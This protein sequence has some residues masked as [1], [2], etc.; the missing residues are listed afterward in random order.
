MTRAA[1]WIVWAA[2]AT[3]TCLSFPQTAAPATL[4]SG[5]QE[6]VVFSGLTNPTDVRFA[7]D[8]RVFV[9]REERAHQGRS[10]SLRTDADGRRRPADRGRRLLGPRAPRPGARPG[11]PGARRTSTSLYTRDA[12]IG[13]TRRGDVG[14]TRARRRP[15]RRPT[16]ASSRPARAADAVGQLDDRSDRCCSTS[17]C[18][19]YPSHSI[20]DLVFGPDGALYVE[21]RRRR[22][23]HLRRLRPGWRLAGSPT[24]KNPCGDPPGGRR[25]HAEPAD[26]RGRRAAGQS[27]RR[28]AGEPGSSNGPSSGSIPT[29]G[30]GAARQPARPRARRERAAASSPTDCAT[31]SASRSAPG[32][33]SS[34]SATSAGATGRRSTASPTRPGRSRTS[35]GPATRAPPAAGLPERGLNICTALYAAGTVDAA[36]TSPRTTRPGRPRRGCPTGG[37][38]IT[39]SRSTRRQLPAVVQRRALLRRLHA[40][41]HLGDEARRERAARPDAGAA[42]AVAASN[43]VDLETGPNGDIFYVDLVG[44][45]IRRIR[46]RRRNAPPTVA[47]RVADLRPASA[48]GELRRRRRRPTRSRRHARRTRGI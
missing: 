43:P 30:R 41:L 23:L 39:G 12:P 20:G 1:R 24:P 37:S 33:T 3:I 28:P 13:G 31:R 26:R 38:S 42:F 46:L 29:H 7:S 45:T 25:R 48:R 16:A 8:G 21:R 27:V 22:Q 2:F 35:A 10:T 5:F 47:H 9:A 36:R 14:T 6:S 40:Q 4:P 17:W 19:Q 18:Q 11:F 44:G 34:G 15:D 32:R